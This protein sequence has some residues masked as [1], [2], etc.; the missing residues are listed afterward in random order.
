METKPRRTRKSPDDRRAEIAATARAIALEEGLD[1]VTQRAVAGRAS[2]ASA[3]VAHYV[4]SMDALVADTFSEIVAEEIGEV[5]ELV[6]AEPSAT[7]GLVVL[8]DAAL[9]PQRQDVTSLWVQAW[10]LGRHNAAL[11]AAVRLRMDEWLSIIRDAITAGAEAG[12]LR[13]DDV[14]GTALHLLA[15]I[16]GLNAHEL[17]HWGAGAAQ[18]AITKRAAEGLLGLAPGALEAAADGASA[19]A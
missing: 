6:A 8:I 19:R 7:A 15:M 2:M 14:D 4:E 13:C 10:S 12:A 16:D 3:L 11:A 17:V 5:R 18:G 1:A 9:D